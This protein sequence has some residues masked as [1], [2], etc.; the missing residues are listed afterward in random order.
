MLGAYRDAAQSDRRPPRDMARIAVR[1]WFCEQPPLDLVK[2]LERA[3][4]FI[5]DDDWILAA[6]WFRGPV[7]TEGD[8]VRSLARAFLER[9]IPCPSVYQEHGRK[10]D[11]VVEAARLSGAEGVVFAAPSFCDPALLEQP[12]AMAAVKDA[13]LPCTAFLYSENTGQYQVI[14]EQAGTFADSIRLW[15]DA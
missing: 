10:G 2:S 3:G 15:S 1:G 5:V 11:A 9:S 7:G 8:P 4:C 13:G 14:R 6:R 12:M